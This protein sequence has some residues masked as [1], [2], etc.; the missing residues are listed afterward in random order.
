M[1]SENENAANGQ[2]PSRVQDLAPGQA[3][4]TAPEP[5]PPVKAEHVITRRAVT[6]WVLYDLANVIF[7][8]GVISLFF[9]LWVR[10]AV[11]EGRA[12]AVKGAID[13]ISMSIIFVASPLLGAMTDRA[14]RRMPFL[15]VS[16]VVCVAVTAFMGRY[17]FYFTAICFII[18][19]I[20]YQ[21][22]VQFY[23][24]LLPEVSTEENRGRVGGIGVGVGYVGSYL[25][26]GLGLWVHLLNNQGHHIGKSTLFLF[27]ALGFLVFAIPCFLFVRERG[28]PNPRPINR[29]MVRE[30]TGETIRTLREGHKYPGLLRFLI[31][32]VFYTDSINTVIFFMSLFTVNVAVNSGLTKEQ[33][34]QRAQIILL[35]AVTFAIAG[36]FIW[37]H[38]T[39]RLGPKRT[40]NYV[41]R[42]W[43]GIFALAAC[44]GLFGLPLWVMY[45]VAALAG[46]ALGGVWAADRPYMLRLTPPSRVGE[47]YG[48]YGM[49]G[50]FSAITGPVLWGA[51]TYLAVNKFHCKALLGQGVAVLA[52]LVMVTVSY[53]ILQP[54]SDKPR[55][56]QKLG[57][58]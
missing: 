41:L 36:G 9:P 20:G 56:W 57:A 37:G 22:G 8:M 13:A 33:G 27:Y 31:G 34:E 10:D 26:V 12:D 53:F 51:I 2:A 43:M 46:F 1:S 18:A 11:G 17:G 32:R 7:S 45:V 4:K 48:L 15:V 39:D 44:V 38:L 21:A 58:H 29:R 28:N 52:L 16:T 55:D 25:A 47:F 14:R 6:S 40:L 30:S 35:S 50:R 19:N 3:P 5:A 49:V 23:D 54:I 24:A 42:T